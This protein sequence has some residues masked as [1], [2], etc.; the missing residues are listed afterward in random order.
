ME[1]PVALVQI[2]TA[3]TSEATLAIEV[4]SE[5]H[6]DG[7]GVEVAGVMIVE[8][9]VEKLNVNIEVQE[10][11]GALRHFAMTEAVIEIDGIGMIASGAAEH[12]HLRVEVDRPIMALVNPFE[13]PL[14]A[15][16]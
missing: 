4:I 15:K 8:I 9:E 10:T 16:I 6:A 14:Q 7:R 13:M 2:A 5:V 12:H 3:G 1:F 11:T